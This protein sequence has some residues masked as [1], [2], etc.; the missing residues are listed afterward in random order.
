MQLRLKRSFPW[1]VLLLF[2]T[3]LVARAAEEGAETGFPGEVVFKWINFAI[4]F[5]AIVYLTWKYAPGFFSSRAAAIRRELEEAKH[6]FE[7]SRKRLDDIERHLAELDR[8]IDKLNRE[9]RE[10]QAAERERSRVAG[11]AEAEKILAAARTEIQATTRAAKIEMKAYAARLA[12]SRAAE[13]IR[14][15]M[16]PERQAATVE[17]FVRS[18][19]ARSRS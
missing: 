13:Q 16:T 2:A 10:E 14:E 8:E 17:R 3:E 1:T 18:L 15:R 9:A 5:G 11:R 7:E 12:V 19:Q 4:V 6:S